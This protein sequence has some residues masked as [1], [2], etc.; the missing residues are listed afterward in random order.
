MENLEWPHLEVLKA[1]CRIDTQSG[2]DEHLKEFASEW[3][4][5]FT[6][7][8]HYIFISLCDKD[9]SETAIEILETFTL[10]F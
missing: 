10:R 1:A 5:I 2:K 8:K 4:R 9:F 7:L 3:N 6:T